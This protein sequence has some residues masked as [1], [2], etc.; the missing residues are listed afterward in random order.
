MPT[1]DEVKEWFKSQPI[2]PGMGHEPYYGGIVVIPAT[3]KIKQTMQRQGSGETYVR[4]V[5]QAVFTPYVKVDTRIAYF[6]DYVRKLNGDQERG[7]FIG[8]I[9]PVEQ[10]IISDPNSAYYNA[11]LPAGFSVHA[12]RVNA[13]EVNRYFIATFR[14]AIY[15]R[16]SY[17]SRVRGEK[18]TPIL[19]GTGSKQTPISKKYPDDNAVMK[20]ETGAIGRALGVAGILVVG[21]GVATAEDVQEAM[22]APVGAGGTPEAPALPADVSL[23]ADEAVAPEGADPGAAEVE[24]APSP[25]DEDASMRETALALQ[26][27]MERDYPEVWAVYRAW[28][29]EM[30]F[31]PLSELSGPALKG[32]VTKLERDLDAAKNPKED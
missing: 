1:E 28:W 17:A 4:E 18:P 11:N 3:E 20:A 29:V 14:V 31:G 6:R 24:Q 16:Q 21:T 25:Q 23:P 2:H 13:T 7:D 32:A 12:V 22:S 10:R 9:E 5:E 27:E 26:A 15:E 8:V 19:Q 30:K